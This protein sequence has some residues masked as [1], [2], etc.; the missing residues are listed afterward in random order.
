M[1]T[2]H[3][4]IGVGKVGVS[5]DGKK[6]IAH[7]KNETQV[8]SFDLDDLLLRGARKLQAYLANHPDRIDDRNL[9][10]EIEAFLVDPK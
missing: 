7:R 5:A 8:W 10:T 9:A 4:G 6:L 2:L 3:A 1:A